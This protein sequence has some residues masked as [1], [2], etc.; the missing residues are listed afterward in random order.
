MDYL[1]DITPKP[2]IARRIRRFA[3]FVIDFNILGAIG[4]VIG[5]FFGDPHEDKEGIGYSLSGLPALA[6]MFL[7]FLLIVVKEGT[8]GQTLG[9]KALKIEVVKADLSPIS[10]SHSI[11]R[12]LFDI[13]DFFLLIGIFVSLLNK[14]K[15][16]IG[17]LVAKTYVVK[18][19]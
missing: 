19:A 10:I 1:T 6:W 15:Q 7:S 14:Y 9:K 11:V 3:A 17:D 16:R 5:F 18:K 13:I 2:V 8:T 4:L 12:H